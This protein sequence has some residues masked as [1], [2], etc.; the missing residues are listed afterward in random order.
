M[1]IRDCKHLSKIISL[2]RKENDSFPSPNLSNPKQNRDD[3]KTQEITTQCSVVWWLPILFHNKYYHKYYYGRNQFGSVDRAS[4][5]GLKGPG[6]DSGQGHVPWLRA[7]PQWGVR[8]RQLINVSLSWMF[9]TLYP[10][11]FL[12]VKKSIKYIIKKRKKWKQN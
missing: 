6:F 9:L 11:L 2:E 12:S 8:R 1:W 5:C 3:I 4:A 10:S 7:H